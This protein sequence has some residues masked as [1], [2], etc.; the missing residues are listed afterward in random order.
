MLFM[1]VLFFAG[2]AGEKPLPSA[3]NHAAQNHRADPAPAKYTRKLSAID[4]SGLKF[5]PWDWED[6]AKGIN[7]QPKRDYTIMLY[8]IGSDLESEEGAGSAD[9]SEMISSGMPGN[10][11]LIL[12]TG[13]ANHW[14]NPEVPENETVIWK[15]DSRGMSELARPGLLNMGDAGTL[16]GFVS[17]ARAAFPSERTGLILWDH[18][19]GAT[20]GYGYDEKFDSSLSLLELNLAFERAGLSGQPLE[21]IGFDACLMASVEMAVIASPYARYM[22]ASQDLEPAD[23]WDYSFLGRLSGGEDG[24]Q[25]GMA[26]ADSFVEF[27]GPAS[28]D[29]LTISVADLGRAGH[30]MDAMDTLMGAALNQ[31]QS[32]GMDELAA[33][34]GA[35]RTFGG[36]SPRDI[37]ADMVDLADMAARLADLYPVQA[38]RLLQALEDVVVYNRHNA[39]LALGGISGYY[40]FSG[41]ED[42]PYAAGVYSTLGMG[43]AYTR[44]QLEFAEHLA[45]NPPRTS[46][47]RSGGRGRY[48]RSQTS[49]DHGFPLPQ[50]LAP[51]IAGEQVDLYAAQSGDTQSL[52][53]TPAALNGEDVNIMVLFSP[54]YPTGRVVGSRKQDGP[55]IQKGIDPLKPGDK[56]A[57]YRREEGVWVAGGHQ[58]LEESPRISWLAADMMRRE[59]LVESRSLVYQFYLQPSPRAISAGFIPLYGQDYIADGKQADKNNPKP[60]PER[61]YHLP[62][63]FKHHQMPGDA[64]AL[65]G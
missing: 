64:Y 10:I 5:T 8:M 2:C 50:N 28:D 1:L 41:G 25:V 29:F 65:G 38:A 16:A 37:Q 30:L 33:R 58:V 35:T 46:L 15:V 13:G 11:N 22:V 60:E 21:F 45:E 49:Q 12:M 44:Y 7:P 19:G 39:H 36:G 48:T 6:A 52:Y 57:F 14:H 55:L 54:D 31:A 20:Q 53:A 18:A 62:G 42:A 40:T 43:G 24:R 27:Y 3:P 34:R 51:F 63:L 26:I 17:F 23:G 32:P 61:V 56:L 9:I 59:R 47:W 4:F